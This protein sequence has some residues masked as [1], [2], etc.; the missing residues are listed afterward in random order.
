MKILCS[1]KVG[2]LFIFQNNIG[3]VIDDNFKNIDPGFCGIRRF[4]TFINGQI[5]VMGV[6]K[7][8]GQVIMSIVKPENYKK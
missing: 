4:L 2:D 6:F 3:I 1:S 7:D 8:N 5:K